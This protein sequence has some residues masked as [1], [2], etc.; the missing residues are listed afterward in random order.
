MLCLIWFID[1]QCLDILP[2]SQ[3]VGEEGSPF[4]PC[5]G[6]A[7]SDRAW[8]CGTVGQATAHNTSIAHM[9]VGESR[10]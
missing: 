10:G 6:F 3:E 1:V 4:W 5:H 2:L 8:H 7:P 9:R